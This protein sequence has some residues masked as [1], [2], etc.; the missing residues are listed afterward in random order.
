MA[1]VDNTTVSD[2][3]TAGSGD[4]SETSSYDE[5]F[6][7]VSSDG[8]GNPPENDTD[9]SNSKSYY[10]K[11]LDLVQNMRNCFAV[12]KQFKEQVDAI[13]LA[14]G[15]GG[16]TII[17][18]NV[19]PQDRIEGLMYLRV[20][21]VTTGKNADGVV[22]PRYKIQSETHTGTIISYFSD[23]DITYYDNSDSYYLTSDNVKEA[24]DELSHRSII[25]KVI[26]PASSFVMVTEDQFI[27]ETYSYAEVAVSGILATDYPVVTLDPA[28]SL[29]DA[30]IQIAQAGHISRIQ[31]FNDK[32]KLFCYDGFKPTIDLPLVFRILRGGVM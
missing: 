22:V 29:A 18:E 19:D 31:T 28:T 2:I 3:T 24:I 9:A 1:D 12:V 8:S 20:T 15:F 10:N 7:L 32:I 16:W 4:G 27:K 5:S 21:D 26:V 13:V 11:D 17:T 23:A 14:S 25:K 30:A 6:G